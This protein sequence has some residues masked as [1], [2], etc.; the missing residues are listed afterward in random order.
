MTQ[1]RFCGNTEAGVTVSG[2]QSGL[3]NSMYE[4]FPILLDE[5]VHPCTREYTY[6]YSTCVKTPQSR[7]QHGNTVRLHTT[8]LCV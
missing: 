2:E 3:Q 4:M 8:T 5:H 1:R 6:T 7:H